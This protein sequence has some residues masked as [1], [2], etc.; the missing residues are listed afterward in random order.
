MKEFFSNISLIIRP[1]FGG[2]LVEALDAY[3]EYD[4]ITAFKIFKKLANQNNPKAQYYLAQM[5][6]KGEFVM[7]D[8]EE[9]ISWYKKAGFL[10]DIESQF[11]LGKIYYKGKIVEKNQSEAKFW[12][13][14]AQKNG[15]IE[16]ENLLLE[17][18]IGKNPNEISFEDA[19]KAFDS[20]DYKKA[21]DLFLILA[22]N[23]DAK[24]QYY[25]GY[26]YEYI[27]E[28][29]ENKNPDFWF[30]KSANNDYAEAQYE[31]AMK[32]YFEN[33]YEDAVLWYEKAAKQGHKDAQKHLGIMY[34][35][36]Y[37][38]QQDLEMAQFWYDKSKE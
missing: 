7:P 21:L 37:G 19:K 6:H 31:M 15:K 29:F 35:L 4:Y 20:E 2:T 14:K 38:I 34:E 9:A 22:K 24:A 18:K 32:C 16:A 3:N 23:D 12:L 26:I 5:Y 1:F 10:E 36:G 17:M 33:S 27:E 11:I 28:K 30:L 13:E 25:I 8:I